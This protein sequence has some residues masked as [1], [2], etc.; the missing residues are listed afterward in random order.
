L[1]EWQ[2]HKSRQPGKADYK[3]FQDLLYATPFSNLSILPAH[4][5]AA[6]AAALYFAIH[7]SQLL[8]NNP[9]VGRDLLV[10][11]LDHLGELGYRHVLLDSR[12]GLTDLGALISGV[13]PLQRTACVKAVRQGARLICGF[14]PWPRR[15]HVTIRQCW[16]RAVS[17]GPRLSTVI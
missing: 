10:G 3:R 13:I 15:Y 7:W 4:G 8:G 11:L 12:T 17:C 16:L 6:D 9:E 14:L 1:I 5:D 2:K